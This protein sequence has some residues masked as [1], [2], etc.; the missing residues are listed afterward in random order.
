MNTHQMLLGLAGLIGAGLAF[1][2]EPVTQITDPH[3]KLA[4]G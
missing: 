2:D 4:P 1:A 3:F